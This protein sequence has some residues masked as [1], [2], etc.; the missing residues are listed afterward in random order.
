[1]RS[2]VPW[3]ELRKVGLFTGV[4][5][6]IYQGLFGGEPPEWSFQLHQFF[7]LGG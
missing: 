2:T 5:D 7:G 1:M 4:H 3:K 6:L